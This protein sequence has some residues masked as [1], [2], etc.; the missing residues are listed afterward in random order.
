M[1]TA[2]YRTK[3]GFAQTA[4]TEMKIR[5]PD[6]MEDSFNKTLDSKVTKETAKENFSLEFKYPKEL[7]KG[8]KLSCRLRHSPLTL[9]AT[10]PWTL[11]SKD[12]PKVTFSAKAAFLSKMVQSQ[13]TCCSL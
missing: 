4:N 11:P 5:P 6:G 3:L 10:S 1:S 8:K 7:L 12:D 13:K 2:E 9:K